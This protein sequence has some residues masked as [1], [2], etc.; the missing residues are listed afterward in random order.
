MAFALAFMMYTIINLPFTN[1]FQNYRCALI[2][3]TM[4]YTLLTTN[5][6]RGMKST[7]PLEIKGRI[8]TPAIIELVLM[9]SCIAVSFFVLA[10]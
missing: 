5:Y 10:Y 9:I 6:Y 3:L 4:L 1:V 7:T 8:Y 2:H